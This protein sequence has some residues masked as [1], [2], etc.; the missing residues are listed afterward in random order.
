MN[1]TWHKRDEGLS[2][3]WATST[4]TISVKQQS[5]NGIHMKVSD[6]K[7]L[8]LK[9]IRKPIANLLRVT[10]F[11][12]VIFIVAITVVPRW[13]HRKHLYSCSYTVSQKHIVVATR[14][15]RKHTAAPEWCHRK[16]LYS[17]TWTVT[18]KT[19]SC[20]YTVTQQT[21]VAHT[22]TVIPTRSHKKQ[23]CCPHVDTK[24]LITCKQMQCNTSNCRKIERSKWE[25]K[26]WNKLATNSD[27]QY[28]SAQQCDVMKCDVMSLPW[29][30]MWFPCTKTDPAEVKLAALADHV[31]ATTVLL[32]G[33]TTSRTLL[34]YNVH[35]RLDYNTHNRAPCY[36]HS[37][38]K[39]Q[40]DTVDTP[41]CHRRTQTRTPTQFIPLQRD[42]EWDGKLTKIN[43]KTLTTQECMKRDS[44]STVA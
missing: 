30:S 28:C 16:H 1:L 44:V 18:Q 41:V 17:C 7:K 11:L 24:E 40:H 19:H 42:T 25:T 22:C 34:S 12:C 32:N 43:Q 27:V 38:Y 33:R 15:H 21:Q 13:C 9:L 26:Y 5:I 10:C 29:R 39:Q 20:A 35:T 14:F 36:R 31:I 6:K 2:G 3:Q 37:P 8:P 4:V 23:L